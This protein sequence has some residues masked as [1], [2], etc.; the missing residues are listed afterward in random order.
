MVCYSTSLGTRH[1]ASSFG[2][3]VPPLRSMA[4]G[5]RLFFFP[6]RI[7][8]INSVA[9]TFVI[10]LLTLFSLFFLLFILFQLFFFLK[11]SST[12]LFTPSCHFFL[13]HFFFHPLS[14]PI[15]ALLLSPS[16]L[17]N[18]HLTDPT[19]HSLSFFPPLSVLLFLSSSPPLRTS[20]STSSHFNSDNSLFF[21]ISYSSSSNSHLRFFD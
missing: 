3:T 15:I 17:P 12:F 4:L 5:H 11:T 7:P 18:H 6:T 9:S 19:F 13:L 20:S 21:S 1:W 2:E 10:C 16:F 14:F 8:S